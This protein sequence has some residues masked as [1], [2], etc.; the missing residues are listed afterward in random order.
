MK[1]NIEKELVIKLLDINFDEK[2]NRKVIRFSI[3][4][5][6][7][8]RIFFE[9]L[10][11]NMEVVDFDSNILEHYFDY[12]RSAVPC[13]LEFYKVLTYV[14]EYINKKLQELFCDITRTINE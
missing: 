10:T 5:N 2:N 11:N 4:S 6:N 13:H 14:R 1:N 8:E 12:F 9:N 7:K 3:F